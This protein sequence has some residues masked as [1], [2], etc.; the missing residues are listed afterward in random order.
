[1]LIEDRP[2]RQA[3]FLN[4]EQIIYLSSLDYLDIPK[5]DEGRGW[6]TDIN[7]NNLQDMN[8][9][10]L[11]I[12]HKSSLK[13]KGLNNLRETCKKGKIDL[14]LFSGGLSQVVYQTKEFQS[15]SINSS[16]LYNDNLNEFLENYSK[17]KTSRL[18]EL[19]YGM[20]WKLEILLRYR[21]L[22][23]RYEAELNDKVKFE[24][25]DELS[26][27]GQTIHAE[28]KNLDNEIDKLL[29]SI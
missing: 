23:T 12:I 27:L 11:V 9:Y 15:L 16:I 24:L 2:G 25:E 22:K 3:Q 19:V 20:H 7:S 13:S 29:I 5:E 14:I 6:I 26:M 4:E 17:G 18:L 1:M 28:I 21:Q 10:S 8:S